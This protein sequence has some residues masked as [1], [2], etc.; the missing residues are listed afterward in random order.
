MTDVSLVEKY[1]MSDDAYDKRKGT[2]R[3]YI[4]QV[5]FHGRGKGKG[6]SG[7]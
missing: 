1:K 7:Y 5:R 3:D 4:R 2:M 6:Y